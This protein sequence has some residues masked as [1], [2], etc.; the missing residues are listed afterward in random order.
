MGDPLEAEE[1]AQEAFTRAL[2]ALPDF[3]GERRFY[4]WMTVIAGRLCVD[5]HRRR[6][7]TEPSATVDLGVIEGGQE[8]IVDEV[9][10]AI[11]AEALGRL[12]PRHREVLDLRE[13]Q[14]WSYLQIADHYGVTLGTVEAL[15]F[16][17]RK[18][19]KREFLAVVGGDRHW[20]GVPVIGAA[21]A[22]LGLAKAKVDGWLAAVAPTIGAPTLAAALAFS[23]VTGAIGGG[24]I[25]EHHNRASG[26]HGPTSSA[27]AAASA[28]PATSIPELLGSLDQ[29]PTTAVAPAN[30]AAAGGA[31]PS[32]APASAPRFD[33]AGV[34]SLGSEQSA[35][36]AE[37]QPVRDEQAG[38][39]YGLD[40]PATISDLHQT[41]TDYIEQ[42][43]G[44]P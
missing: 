22:R 10:L 19:L 44:Q 15:L 26:T 29:R 39:F 34:H 6:G 28:T 42:L 12:A 25:H 3:E 8:Q 32:A 23:A 2:R 1:I 36:E 27:S 20:V 9:D 16:R 41:A 43:G 38:V 14:G 4:P 31:T 24:V 5:A 18:A 13:Q 21:L 33:A 17:A 37:H 40:A 7:R 35:A 30:A 11:L